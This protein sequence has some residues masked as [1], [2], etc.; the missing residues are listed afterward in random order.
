MSAYDNNGNNINETQVCPSMTS[1][2]DQEM[3]RVVRKSTKDRIIS[4]KGYALN[5]Q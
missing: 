2:K 3:D 1:R 5:M 4:K